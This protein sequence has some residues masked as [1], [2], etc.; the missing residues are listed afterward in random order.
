MNK[1]A[2]VYPP[3]AIRSNIRVMA[4]ALAQ[5]ADHILLGKPTNHLDIR[6]QHEALD[7]M[8]TLP[9]GATV[10]LQDLNLAARC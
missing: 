3:G 6:Y 4:R 7:L 5:G 9:S 2:G 8:A 10:V 1:Y